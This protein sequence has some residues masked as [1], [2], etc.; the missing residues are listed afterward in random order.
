[1]KLQ[2]Y[3]DG[4]YYNKEDA[5]ISVFDHGLLFGDGV[6]E[7]IRC[8]DGRP[9]RL[10]Q[11]L[12][13]LWDSAKAIWLRIP[14]SQDEL[15]AAVIETLSINKIRDGYVRLIV[16]RGT[17]VCPGLV[18]GVT[19]LPD[20]S[21]PGLDFYRSSNPHV[22]MIPDYITVYPEEFYTHGLHI[23]TAE[24]I[25]NH[26]SALNP[27]IKSLAYLNNVLAKIEAIQAGVPEAL[28]LN[29]KGELAECTVDNIFLVRDG[30][31]RT[32][33]VTA[34]I[35]E[36]VTRDVIL[37][38]ASEVGIPTEETTLTKDDL[39]SADECFLTGTAI[40]VIPVIQVDEKSIG[41]GR[42]GPVTIDLINRFRRLTRA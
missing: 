21:S 1:M 15:A 42:P 24:T 14:V 37:K 27:R 35:L 36:G 4:E 19:C 18:P 23:V 5:K 33:P 2:I 39:Y 22:I 17:E 6:F 25:R 20:G 12:G 31:I 41:I 30:T 38:L 13:R 11:H 8:Y 10:E 16:T 29:H 28:M 3:I 32:P 40:E 26:P 9:F 34:G 7:G